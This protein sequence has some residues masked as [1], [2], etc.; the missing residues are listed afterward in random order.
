MSHMNLNKR[1]SIPQWLRLDQRKIPLM[2]KK[3]LNYD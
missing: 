3:Q 1:I 2:I